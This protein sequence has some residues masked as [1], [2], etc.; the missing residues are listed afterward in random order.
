MEAEQQ[1]EC[2]RRIERGSKL[3]ASHEHPVHH[4]THPVPAAID[5]APPGE[6]NVRIDARRRLD[7]RQQGAYPSIDLVAVL[8]DEGEPTRPRR[9]VDDLRDPVSGKDVFGCTRPATR[10]RKAPR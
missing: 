5:E 2:E 8:D 6:G 4:A 10:D 1:V 9:R 7:G 3:A